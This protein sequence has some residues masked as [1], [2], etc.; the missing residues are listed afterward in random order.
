MYIPRATVYVSNFHWKVNVDG[1]SAW[2]QM[3]VG[4]GPESRDITAQ[5]RLTLHRFHCI[6]SRPGLDPKPV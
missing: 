6:N 1:A 3:R 4:E 5:G 2:A